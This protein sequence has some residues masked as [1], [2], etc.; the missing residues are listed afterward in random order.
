MFPNPQLKQLNIYRFESTNYDTDLVLYAQVINFS[1]MSVINYAAAQVLA[2]LMKVASIDYFA[3]NK[4]SSERVSV[5]VVR[6]SYDI[7]II[8]NLLGHNAI[9]IEKTGEGFLKFVQ[10]E[11]NEYDEERFSMIRMKVVNRLDKSYSNIKNFAHD[12]ANDI[13]LSDGKLEGV[14]PKTV[15]LLKHE[16]DQATLNHIIKEKFF[17]GSNRIIFEIGYKFNSNAMLVCDVFGSLK[18]TVIIESA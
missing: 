4:L 5:E 10:Q 12:D 2:E 16:T 13:Y 17:E 7:L 18:P 1:V 3:N 6:A 11:F 9:Q 14:R 8:F 15:S